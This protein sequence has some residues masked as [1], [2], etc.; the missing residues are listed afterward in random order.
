MKKVVLKVTVKMEL[1]FMFLQM[2]EDMRASSRTDCF[3]DKELRPF[4]MVE[5][6]SVVSKTENLMEMEF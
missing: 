1:G 2:V 5:N 4:L 6:I 3:M